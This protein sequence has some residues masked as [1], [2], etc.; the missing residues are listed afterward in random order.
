[1]MTKQESE[2]GALDKKLDVIIREQDNIR[3]KEQE[4]MLSKFINIQS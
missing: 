2:V 4:A 1:M 3:K